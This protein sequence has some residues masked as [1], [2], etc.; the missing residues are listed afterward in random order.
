LSRLIVEALD[1]R[2][3]S[4]L[5]QLDAQFAIAHPGA[6]DQVRHEVGAEGHETADLQL[7]GR[8]IAG[9][10]PVRAVLCG[11]RGQ[12]HWRAIG[13]VGIDQGRARVGHG[14]VGDLADEDEV[15]AELEL[16]HEPA[17]EGGQRMHERRCA[18]GQ[19]LPVRALELVAAGGLETA[20]EGVGDE[21]LIVPQHVDAKHAVLADRLGGGAQVVHADQQG[22]CVGGDR[23]HGADRDPGPPGGAVGGHDRNRGSG[24]AHAFQEEIAHRNWLLSER[25][26]EGKLAF[27]KY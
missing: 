15:G 20:G 21:R 25:T 27:L 11:L 14:D 16:L 18:R 24:V 2:V 5:G 1:Q 23:A 4:A 7:A 13:P 10:W 9:P 19:H 26:L 8:G 12:W 22:R 3:L 17:V 6:R